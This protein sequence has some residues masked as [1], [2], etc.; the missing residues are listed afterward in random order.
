MRL[1]GGHPIMSVG[2]LAR[3]H[4]ANI[5]APEAARRALRR[6]AEC[7]KMRQFLLLR[8]FLL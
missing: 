4:Y 3:S 7:I 6:P 5:G 1:S 8:Q 2:L